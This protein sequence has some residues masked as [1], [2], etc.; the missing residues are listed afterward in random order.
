MENFIEKE[1]LYNLLITRTPNL[2][3]KLLFDRLK[4][5]KITITKEQ[6][7][8]LVIL[9]QNE[10]CSQQFLADETFRDKP[11]I[12]RLIHHLEKAKIVERRTDPF[13][14]RSNL[15]YLTNKGI[16]LEKKVMDEVRATVEDALA[17]IDLEEAKIFKKVFIELHQHFLASLKESENEETD[18]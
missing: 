5:K 10:G 8:L 2:M 4:K 16:L 13:D 15:I 18:E 7:S 11:G 17:S 12:T 6:F 1:D 9:W 3:L 14:R